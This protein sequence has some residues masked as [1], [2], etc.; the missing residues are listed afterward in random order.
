MLMNQ[1]HDTFAI[2]EIVCPQSA[3][4]RIAHNSGLATERWAADDYDLETQEGHQL[5]A[6]TLCELRPKMV[7]LS[8]G[9]IPSRKT[10]NL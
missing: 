5:A 9:R 10:K 8:P 4:T 6:Q 3:S 7:W 1:D 2:I